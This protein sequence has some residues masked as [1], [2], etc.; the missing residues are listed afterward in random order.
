MGVSFRRHFKKKLLVLKTLWFVT[1]ILH[2]VVLGVVL[3]F[4][5]SFFVYE[6]VGISEIILI[7]LAI[8]SALISFWLRTVIFSKKSL[9]KALTSEQ[10]SSSEISGSALIK[11]DLTALENKVL[12]YIEKRFVGYSLA[13]IVQL[14]LNLDVAMMGFVMQF[15]QPSQSVGLYLPF[16]LSAFAL[17]VSIFPNMEKVLNGARTLSMKEE[18]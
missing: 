3:V 14:F 1:T 18:S 12:C 2:F 16:F 13:F 10:G 7:G 4:S 5:E 6:E 8:I 17:Q 15:I 9:K 11:E